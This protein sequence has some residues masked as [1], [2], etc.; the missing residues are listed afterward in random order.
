MLLKSSDFVLHDLSADSVFEVCVDVEDGDDSEGRDGR[1]ESCGGGGV[2]D[3][4]WKGKKAYELE[5]LAR[6]ICDRLAP[7]R[8]TRLGGDQCISSPK[9]M[10]I[11]I[12]SS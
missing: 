8:S 9:A 6:G 11:F 2:R 3:G 10:N 1:R 5:S 7:F 12:P 4:R